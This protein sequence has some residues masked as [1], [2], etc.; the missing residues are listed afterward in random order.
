[1][2]NNYQ[3][4]IVLCLQRKNFASTKISDVISEIK[5]EEEHGLMAA[6]MML[7]KKGVLKK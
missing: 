7:V 6:I 3:L 2:L 1:M 4:L 5:P